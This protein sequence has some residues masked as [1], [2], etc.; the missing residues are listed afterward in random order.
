MN[1]VPKYTKEGFLRVRV[2]GWLFD[3]VLSYYSEN[4]VVAHP[5]LSDAIGSYLTSETSFPASMLLMPSSLQKSIVDCMLPILGRWAKR[6]LD[7]TALYGIRIY[8]RG[9]K[10][11]MHVDKVDTHQVS[12]I[13]NVGQ[14]VNSEWPL[15]IYDHDGK[16]HKVYMKPGEA[17]LYE[18]ARLE[19]GRPE[20]LD[21]DSYAN[22][23]IHS[24]ETSNE[25]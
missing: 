2:P 17:I 3:D 10:L 15:Y 11:K 12:A 23:F 21:G 5:E 4:A 14:D 24:K 18:S 9:S 1:T 25:T 8:H 16:L 19:H 7:F 22:F 13:V 6:D 20:T